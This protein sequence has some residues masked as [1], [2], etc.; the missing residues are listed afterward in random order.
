MGIFTIFKKLFSNSTDKV[1]V[2]N[3]T[4]FQDNCTPVKINISKEDFDDNPSPDIV[5]ISV[6]LK[7]QFLQNA[8]FIRMKS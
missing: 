4:S 8:G 3:Q 5:P 6:L 2:T 1:P 7:K